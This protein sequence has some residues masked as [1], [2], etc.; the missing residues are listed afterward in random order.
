MK[1][2][3]FIF[4][5][6]SITSCGVEKN[7]NNIESTKTWAQVQVTNVNVST[8][9]ATE[10][11]E[12]W[13]ATWK[14]VLTN[15]WVNTKEK[16]LTNTWK[17][18]LENVEETPMPVINDKVSVS[19]WEKEEKDSIVVVDNKKTNWNVK[20]DL[21]EKAQEEVIDEMGDYVNDL[22]NMIE[23]DVK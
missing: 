4:V 20:V 1:K 23:N 15:T 6:L 5:L 21:D 17:K 2:F 16:I 9:N 10:L 18:V 8:W 14:T 11:E 19:S 13:T 7:W 3:I 22:F 12:K